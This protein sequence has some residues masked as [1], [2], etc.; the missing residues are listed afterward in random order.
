VGGAGGI[1]VRSPDPVSLTLG[2]AE[3][4]RSAAAIAFPADQCEISARGIPHAPHG[5]LLG[6][7]AR[8]TLL[9][10]AA[11]AAEDAEDGD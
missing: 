8:E 2:V 6:E 11:A 7:A 9:V 4:A 3:A 1:R 10:F 5:R